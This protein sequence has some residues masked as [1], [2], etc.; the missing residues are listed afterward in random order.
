V[1]DAVTADKFDNLRGYLAKADKDRLVD[2]KTTKV[3]DL[4]A[5]IN[6][7]RN[8]F[9]NKYNQEFD[10]QGDHLSNAMV[11]AGQDKKSATVTLSN[12]DLGAGNLNNGNGINRTDTVT[13][14]TP[15]AYTPTP[16][17]TNQP[18][19]T[20]GAPADRTLNTGPDQVTVSNRT[21]EMSGTASNSSSSGKATGPA[22]NGENANSTVRGND[23]TANPGVRNL[24]HTMATDTTTTTT[25][26]PAAGINGGL[27]SATGVSINLVNEGH[28]MNA[29]RINIPDQI[30]AE[31]LKQNLVKHIQM[32]DDQK[33]TWPSDVNAAYRATACH[34][35]QAFGDSSLASER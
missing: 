34:I 14:T 18:G 12:A 11:F 25:L 9:K 1:N 26:P 8:D 28:V 16:A 23:T 4:N 29:W 21:G 33:A 24:D 20:N 2:M 35:L 27:A 31:Q 30:S 22:S 6:Q 32:L 15:P 10:I 5:A 17:N 3:D 19:M 13:T 7:F